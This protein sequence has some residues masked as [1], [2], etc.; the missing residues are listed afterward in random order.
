MSADMLSQAGVDSDLA[1]MVETGLPQPTMPTPPVSAPAA[2]AEDEFELE[3]EPMP[4]A[5]T[6]APAAGAGLG[7]LLSQLYTGD[8]AAPAPSSASVASTPSYAAE[9]STPSYVAE[10]S[11]PSYAAESGSSS[12][13]AETS[14]PSYAAESSAPSFAS[15]TSTPSYAAESSAP[16][17][18]AESSVPSYVQE[19]TP[20]SYAAETSSFSTA[21]DSSAPGTSSAEPVSVPAVEYSAPAA[22]PAPAFGDASSSLPAQGGRPEGAVWFGVYLRRDADM[23]AAGD[24]RDQLSTVLGQDVPLSLLVARAAQQNIAQLGLNSVAIQDVISHRARSIGT[25]GASLRDSLSALDRDHDGQADLVVVNAG[26]FELDDLHY[27]D[28]LTLSVGRV[29]N[30]RAALSLNGDVDTGRAADFL[31]AV[32]RSLETPVALII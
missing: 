19:A 32:A 13:A 30:G 5:S 26:T 12:Y 22:A 28:M 11:T 16:S 15:E 1:A 23:T 27:P 29:E 17:Y 10:S 24:L 6:P 31:A 7:G 25:A 8:S 9:T 4:A 20:P 21:A 14:A 18:T 2:P 3:D